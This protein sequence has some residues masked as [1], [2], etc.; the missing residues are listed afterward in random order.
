MTASHPVDDAFSSDLIELPADP[1]AFLAGR[2]RRNVIGLAM[3]AIGVAL[4]VSGGA[5]GWYIGGCLIAVAIVILRE[6]YH[7][8]T[9]DLIRQQVTFVSITL[10]SARKEL[11]PFD[12]IERLDFK[13]GRNGA[14]LW[15]KNGSML[16]VA[17][18]PDNYALLDRRLAEI[19]TR[20][21][22][23]AARGGLP[24][25]DVH[26]GASSAPIGAETITSS[27]HHIMGSIIGGSVTLL[28]TVVAVVGWFSILLTEPP[29]FFGFFL[30]F[31]AFLVLG[32]IGSFG[33]FMLSSAR[34]K[35]LLDPVKRQL[36]IERGFIRLKRKET[37]AFEE[38]ARAGVIHN[39]DF[40]AG[41][42]F[43]PYFVLKSHRLI[44]LN[45][46][47]DDFQSS[48]KVAER[49]RRMTGAERRNVG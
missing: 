12:A 30:L 21:G 24:H 39:H 15:L 48:D 7:L 44:R 40:R 47:G 6:R 5:A 9:F 13:P 25:A 31:L 3:M 26:S 42:S 29:S 23:S 8:A 20:T 28:M 2:R 36:H 4:F 41:S 16:T 45:G 46:L 38:V 27:S 14:A 1:I 18:V 32:L 34:T 22:L 17:G 49:V 10:L 37:I 11:L 35:L 33:V 19:R 43:T